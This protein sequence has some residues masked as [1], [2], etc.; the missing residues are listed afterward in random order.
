MIGG[1][2]GTK[3]G[4]Q[5]SCEL[6]DLGQKGS[7]PLMIKQRCERAA[8]AWRI[9]SSSSCSSFSLKLSEL[10]QTYLFNEKKRNISRERK[11]EKVLR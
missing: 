10:R 9:S 11:R 8:Y 1:G 4:L 6:P 3:E 7:P 5:E 2:F